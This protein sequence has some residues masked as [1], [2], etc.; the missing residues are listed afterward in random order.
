MTIKSSFELFTLLLYA[1]NQ[2]T[3]KGRTKLT[4]LLFLLVKNDLF[5]NIE[6]EFK[7]E[8]Y[9]FGPWSH[10]A[11]IDLPNTLSD[12]GILEIEKDKK[13][14]PLKEN[15]SKDDHFNYKI[16]EKGKKV[17]EKLLSRIEGEEIQEIEKIKAK[18][19]D[20]P[21]D[22]LID[23]VYLN[24]VSYTK[25]SKIKH[26]VFSKKGLDP[27]LLELV[28]IIPPIPLEDEKEYLKM[29]LMERYL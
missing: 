18:W 2:K 22:L 13:E 11:G 4:K 12:L 17:A 6:K 19:N 20:K 26:Q 9:N 1:D 7:F 25:N 10:T 5:K 16:T 8:A 14:T 15:Q 21:I 27:E 24:F 23:Y 3:I 28:G 29:I